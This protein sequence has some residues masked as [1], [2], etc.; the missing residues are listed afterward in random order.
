M[1][2]AYQP[3]LRDFHAQS[4]TFSQG[5]SS[6]SRQNVAADPLAVERDCCHSLIQVRERDKSTEYDTG[7]YLDYYHAAC[8][9]VI[10]MAIKSRKHCQGINIMV[11]I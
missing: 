9:Q 11:Y 6:R 4:P 5:M 2:L 3:Q 1:F 10:P 7:I 8:M